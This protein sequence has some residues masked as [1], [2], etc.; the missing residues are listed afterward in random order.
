MAD[1]LQPAGVKAVIQDLDQYL[2]G[3]DQMNRATSGI[4]KAAQDAANQSGNASGQFD[5]LGNAIGGA[6]K[7]SDGFKT[8]LDQVSGSVAGLLGKLAPLGAAIA[9]AFAIGKGVQA[10]D[11]LGASIFRLQQTTNLTS[12]EASKLKFS[13]EE[14][15]VSAGIG[16]RAII[17]FSRA[18]GGVA[19][20]EDGI[21]IPTG[22]GMADMLYNLGIRTQD[23]D[24]KTRPLTDVI[25]DLAEE[26]KNMPD[27]VEKTTLATNLFGRSGKDLI[28]LL[29]QGRDG[30]I[31]MGDEAEK[32]GLVLDQHTT[33]AVRANSLA[34][35][36]FHAALEGISVQLGLAFIPIITLAITV[37][38]KLAV[39]FNQKVV[40]AI[41]VA[42]GIF[43]FFVSK[44]VAAIAPALNKTI[45]AVSDF[46]D[47]LVEIFKNSFED[48][49]LLAQDIA[50]F[51]GILQPVAVAV[52]YLGAAF[53]KAI[54]YVQ[55]FVLGIRVAIA[56]VKAIRADIT[57]FARILEFF[58]EPV[59]KI[60]ISV[61]LFVAKIIELG[62]AIARFIGGP[63]GLFSDKVKAVASGPM[64]KF[65]E[66]AARL[67]QYIIPA[68]AA[69][70][71]GFI[72]TLAVGTVLG[73][74]T[75]VGGLVSAFANF[76]PI[77]L[78]IG[79]IQ[80]FASALLAPFK[81][82]VNLAGD[83]LEGIASIGKFILQT[84]GKVLSFTLNA[85]GNAL[86]FVQGLIFGGVQELLNAKPLEVPIKTAAQGPGIGDVLSGAETGAAKGA[87]EKG[88]EAAAGGFLSTFKDVMTNA[89]GGLIGTVFGNV[90]SSEQ[91]L[92]VFLRGYFDEFGKNIAAFAGVIGLLFSKGFISGA[93]TG[94]RAAGPY[95][96]LADVVIR[97]ILAA[98]AFK[99][100]ELSKG[101]V[102]LIPIITGALGATLGLLGGPFAELTV[103]AGFVIGVGIGEGIVLALKYIVSP[104]KLGAVILDG[105]RGIP[106]ALG[107]GL[108]AVGAALAI[109][110]VA[111]LIILPGLILREL[112]KLD[113]LGSELTGVIGRALAESFVDGIKL[114]VRSLSSLADLTK[115]FSVFILTEFAPAAAKAVARALQYIFSADFL[116]DVFSLQWIPAIL[117]GIRSFVPTIIPALKNFIG[118]VENVFS[119]IRLP[120]IL[121]GVLDFLIG[122]VTKWGTGV[123]D[124]FKSVWNDANAATGNALNDAISEVGDKLTTILDKVTTFGSDVVRAFNT[125]ADGIKGAFSSVLGVVTGI[126]GTIQSVVISSVSFLAGKVAD[127]LGIVKDGLDALP[128]SNPAGNAIQAAIDGLRALG[129]GGGS[130]RQPGEPAPGQPVLTGLPGSGNPGFASGTRAPLSRTTSA[131]VGESG[132]E[133]ALLRRGR[134]VLPAGSEVLNATSTSALLSALNNLPTRAGA[135]GGAGDFNLSIP[136]AL[137]A[138]G[139]GFESMRAVVHAE[140]DR[141]LINSRSRANRAGAPITAGLG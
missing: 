119:E 75:A 108:G 24:G 63:L 2:R 42:S 26:F 13:F 140:L 95:L 109:G 84:A 64:E 35:K 115:R 93:L 57:N 58:P 60:I 141:Q 3:A 116:K 11:E 18:L 5:K 36:H 22:K 69:A 44:S 126:F 25:A 103:P 102:N 30:I 136:I 12:E 37:G 110:L 137:D 45:H 17:K 73:F 66:V 91:P 86:E 54:E 62:D 67:A 90:I 19:D 43:N 135:G 70:I 107:A 16:E 77:K 14:Q 6:G 133:L 134:A 112:N 139:M 68:L 121:G 72:A 1:N 122:L 94:L 88:G 56:I 83:A 4:G 47:G 76:G 80:D 51:P 132:T 98:L 128:G 123:V 50:R 9:G 52:A 85:A 105:I 33:D 7:E 27:G 78:A 74:V 89:L 100:G 96:A 92:F 111:G 124:G 65:R 32:L 49:D 120:D 31:E 87:G 79:L 82:I 23:V 53:R 101:F 34:M 28:P 40:P 15:G 118:Q 21:A 131:F 99:S 20:L 71:L 130:T 129:G 29:N 48:F 39:A 10:V 41:K 117:S 81:F 113:K 55:K 127:F 97:G 38:T 61:A 104:R 106:R 59:Q 46:V 114:A 138:R 125:I 8:R